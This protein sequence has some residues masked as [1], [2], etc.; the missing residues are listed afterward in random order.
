MRRRTWLTAVAAVST[1]RGA[2]L[3]MALLAL[4]FTASAQPSMPSNAPVKEALSAISVGDAARLQALL[5][6]DVQLV[7]GD[8]CPVTKPCS[9]REAFLAALPAAGTLGIAPGHEPRR[10]GNVWR[11]PLAIQ[12]SEGSG[13]GGAEVYVRAD[14]VASVII[15]FAGAQTENRAAPGQRKFDFAGIDATTAADLGIAT[16]AARE[17]LKKQLRDGGVALLCRHGNTHWA[18]QDVFGRHYTPAQRN[19]RAAQRTLSALGLAEATVIAGALEA[20]GVTVSA[21]FSTWFSRTREFGARIAGI[22]PT[23]TDALSGAPNITGATYQTLLNEAAKRPGI[24]LLSAHNEPFTSMNLL[25]GAPF[26]EGDCVVLKATADTSFTVLSH[27][28]PG[29]WAQLARP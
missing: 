16:R 23:V 4:P 1:C 28:V 20:E 12:P 17:G 11:V 18:E 14:R 15:E 13:T 29:Q 27:L 25:R 6:E 7:F 10:T 24:T 19:E 21:A 2:L 26:R 5:T 9:G 22:E 8:R 3:A